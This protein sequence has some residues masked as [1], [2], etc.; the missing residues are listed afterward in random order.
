MSA[1]VS[2]L[3]FPSPVGTLSIFADGAAL[4]V[5]EWGRA[6]EPPPAAEATRA[7]LADAR[8]QLDAYFDGKAIAFAL[9]L[10]PAGNAFQQSVWQAMCA[11]PY[12]TTRTYGELAADLGS[13]ARAVGTACGANPI[14]IIIPCHRVL[15]A[16]NRMTGYSGGAGVETKIQLLQLEGAALI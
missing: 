15:G 1:T 10:A 4:T 5:V 9:P 2:W 3:S 12:G 6:P 8:A 7:L 11:I 14:P 13:S 16:G